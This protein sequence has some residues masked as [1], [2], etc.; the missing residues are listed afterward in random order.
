MYSSNPQLPQQLNI[1]RQTLVRY[2]GVGVHRFAIHVKHFV[3]YYG[4]GLI[5]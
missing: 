2:S 1:L 4:D 3:T 5:L